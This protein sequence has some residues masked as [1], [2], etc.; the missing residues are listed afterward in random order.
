[1]GGELSTPMFVIAREPDK[2]SQV[3]VK[4]TYVPTREA[5][6][7]ALALNGK[8]NLVCSYATTYVQ[9]L[10][11]FIVVEQTIINT[12]SLV[13]AMTVLGRS[14]YQSSKTAIN[15]F[16]EFVHF[17][18]EAEGIRTFAYHPGAII[19][20]LSPLEEI[21]PQLQHYFIDT[22][23]LAASFALWLTT[24]GE[25]VNFLRGKFVSA[26]WDVEEL[27]AMKDEIEGRDLLWTRVVGQEQ[28]MQ[29]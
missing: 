22:T 11:T 17:E 10:T 5:I 8:P 1:M 28:V 3:N 24:T 7:R 6:R 23:E 9:A 26:N 4:G 19:T 13:S 18:Y 15:R 14:S 27:L 25:R 12:S 16:T 20:A 2:I 21:P 29:K